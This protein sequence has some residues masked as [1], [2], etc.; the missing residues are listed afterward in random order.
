MNLKDM[1]D[2]RIVRSGTHTMQMSTKKGCLVT[3]SFMCAGKCDHSKDLQVLKQAL[4]RHGNEERR[5]SIA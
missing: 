4:Q 2:L 5:T 3:L 1:L